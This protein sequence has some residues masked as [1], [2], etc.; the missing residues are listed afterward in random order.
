MITKISE[1]YFFTVAG[2]WMLIWILFAL[3]AVLLITGCVPVEPPTTNQTC[4]RSDQ[5]GTREGTTVCMISDN[6]TINK[7]IREIFAE[8]G[9]LP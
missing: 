1:K 4:I 7:E 2:F 9:K 3:L 8:G 5:C 6:E